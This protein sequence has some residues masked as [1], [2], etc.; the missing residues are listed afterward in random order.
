MLG[1][2]VEKQVPVKSLVDNVPLASKLDIDRV[3]ARRHQRLIGRL[4]VGLPAV[5]V[6]PDPVEDRAARKVCIIYS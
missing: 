6:G 5:V 3:D 2:K 1:P 4:D